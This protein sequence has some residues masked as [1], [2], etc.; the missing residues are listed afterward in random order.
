MIS[1]IL[2]D[3]QKEELA[4]LALCVKESVADTTDDVSRILTCDNEQQLN[5]VL[6]GID[7]ADAGYIAFEEKN[8]QQIVRM[9]RDRF[10]SALL[11]LIVDNALSPREYIRPGILA[12]M[13]L[14][15]PYSR[16][17]A[18]ETFKGF[19]RE[20]MDNRIEDANELFVIDAKNG[21]TK[22]PYGSISYFEAT[23][24]KIYVRLTKEEYGFYDTLD[25]LADRLPDNFV[26]CH[27][28]FIVNKDKIRQ[29]VLSENTLVLNNDLKIPVSRSYR[30]RIRDMLI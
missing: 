23:S 6:N 20:C 12:S 13:I 25:N 15:R 19:I 2:Y 1:A 8:G 24:K 29:F 30:N 5:E 3:K 7:V 27:R 10:P 17:E 16:A 4:E 11:L 26:R 21:I 28:S 22:V 18:L 14:I 9:I